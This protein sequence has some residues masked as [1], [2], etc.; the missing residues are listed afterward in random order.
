MND[1]V[2]EFT[3]KFSIGVYHGAFSNLCYLLLIFERLPLYQ[4][5][6]TVGSLFDSRSLFHLIL[7]VGDMQN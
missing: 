2:D 4:N 5:V 7:S 1:S 6:S 3:K